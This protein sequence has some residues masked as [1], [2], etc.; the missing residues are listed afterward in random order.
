MLI[1]NMTPEE[2]IRHFS[3][4]EDEVTASV[5]DFF[6]AIIDEMAGEIAFL[7]SDLARL[8]N[9]LEAAEIAKTELE[10]R[11]GLLAISNLD[12]DSKSR[13][14]RISGQYL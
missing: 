13:R 6:A 3:Q 8:E 4:H 7:E 1:H 12:C 11:V 14:E 10:N 2:A 5:C 9:D